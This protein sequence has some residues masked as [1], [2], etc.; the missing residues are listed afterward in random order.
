MFNPFYLILFN[1]SAKNLQSKPE[2]NDFAYFYMILKHVGWH[3]KYYSIII[4]I[5]QNSI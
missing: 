5:V 3:P 4:K 2:K 1:K